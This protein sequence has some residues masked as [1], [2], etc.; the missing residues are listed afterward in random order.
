MTLLFVTAAFSWDKKI[1]HYNWCYDWWHA[2]PTAGFELL[3]IVVLLRAR[4]SSSGLPQKVFCAKMRVLFRDRNY[5]RCESL[6]DILYTV[7][8]QQY[9]AARG[10]Q[11]ATTSSIIYCRRFE[12]LREAENWTPACHNSPFDGQVS[13]TS[14]QRCSFAGNA[15]RS[16]FSPS[17]V[18][19]S[20]VG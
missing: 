3:G 13:T 2:H 12:Q 5:H 19:V 9:H 20:Y 11:E 17:P 18:P 4:I 14:S 6:K 8:K 15:K 1:Q 16:S 10:K 7:W